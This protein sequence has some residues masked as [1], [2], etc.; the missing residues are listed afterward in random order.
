MLLASSGATH[1][2]LYSAQI[3]EYD[4]QNLSTAGTAG[5]RANTGVQ[6]ECLVCMATHKATSTQATSV[7]HAHVQLT[8]EAACISKCASRLYSCALGL[9][10]R[11]HHSGHRLDAMRG[12]TPATLDTAARDDFTTCLPAL[13]HSV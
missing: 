7:P 4:R 8:V 2:Q 9:R 12:D 10:Y 5:T 6:M 1:Q 11:P 3:L 13:Q